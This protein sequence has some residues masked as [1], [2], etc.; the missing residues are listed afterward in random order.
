MPMEP[1]IGCCTERIGLLEVQLCCC[2]SEDRFSIP[3]CMPARCPDTSDIPGFHFD[4]QRC[5]SSIPVASL[6]DIPAAIENAY[7]DLTAAN[8]GDAKCLRIDALCGVTSL[9]NTIITG[10]AHDSPHVIRASTPHVA[11]YEP[12]TCIYRA[13][14]LLSPSVALSKE[15]TLCSTAPCSTAHPLDAAP[16]T[17]KG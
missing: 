15:S 6:P 17:R 11:A 8:Q 13:A 9:S 3:S 10:A 2:G 12:H 4:L 14:L 5:T 1:R 16:E 7:I